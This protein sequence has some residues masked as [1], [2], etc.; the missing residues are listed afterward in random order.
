MGKWY[1]RPNQILSSDQHVTVCREKHFTNKIIIGASKGEPK[2]H[3]YS[4]QISLA[5]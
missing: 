2:T 4:S 1:A 5:A 3:E